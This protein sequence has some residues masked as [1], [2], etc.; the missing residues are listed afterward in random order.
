MKVKL[1]PLNAL[2]PTPVVLVGCEREGCINYINIAHIGILD[3]HTLSLSLN[4]SHFT[5]AIIK[6]T[7][8]LSINIP[9]ESM[10]EETDYVGL[11]SG[12]NVDKSAVFESFYGEMENVPMIK[13][14][15][16]NM[17]CE[18]IEIIELKNHEV[19]IVKSK[20]TY[21]D[22]EVIEN[23]KINLNLVKPILFDMHQRKYFT[24]GHDFA[25][26]WSA[27]RALIKK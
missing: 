23:G 19:F 10:V 25:K 26:A 24:L 2:Y 22:E 7:M 6:E 8:R 14:A 3:I 13:E 27:G 20:H 21:A 12:K 17:A 9:K 11:V 4:K 15:P 18:V 5:N 16:I 1:G